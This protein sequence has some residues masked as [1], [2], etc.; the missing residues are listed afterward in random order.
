MH[1]NHESR[2]AIRTLL[3]AAG[4]AITAS[5]LVDRV[6]VDAPLASATVGVTEAPGGTTGTWTVIG[7]ALCGP[8]ATP[9]Q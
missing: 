3:R 1:R 9:V 4:A 2:D 8:G 6:S 7:F 5:L